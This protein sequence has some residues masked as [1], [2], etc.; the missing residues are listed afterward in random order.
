[1]R[2]NFYYYQVTE[3]HHKN[4]ATHVKVSYALNV[5][6]YKTNFGGIPV[7]NHCL[8]LNPNFASKLLGALC[9]SRGS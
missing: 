1:M 2:I 9:C 3:P 4:N 8:K 5:L 7:Q 6:L